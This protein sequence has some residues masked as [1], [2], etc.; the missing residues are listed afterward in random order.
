MYKLVPTI[1]AAL[2]LSQAHA[3]RLFKRKYH[4]LV[5]CEGQKETDVNEAMTQSQNFADMIANKWKPGK[6]G[7]GS[8]NFGNGYQATMDKYMGTWSSYN[9]WWPWPSYQWKTNIQG[10]GA[11]LED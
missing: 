9:S 8:S 4:N 6:Y 2:L 11:P 1:L 7:S 5:Q 10:M 3:A